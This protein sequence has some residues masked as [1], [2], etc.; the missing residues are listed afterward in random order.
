M[1]VIVAVYNVGPYIERCLHS[2]FGQTL[3]DMEYIFIDDGSTDGSDR[4]IGEVLEQ[5]PHRKAQTRIL[6]HG[7]NRGIAA[8]R[9]TGI[10]AATGEYVIHCDADDY[11]EPNMYR[12]LY[13][14]AAERDADI[15][16]CYYYKE[17]HGSSSVIHIDYRPTA[18]ESL[19]NLYCN[20]EVALWDKLV[21]RSLI[22]R[23]DIVPYEGVDYW[24]DL[25]CT[26]RML[27]YAETIYTVK[28]PLYHYCCRENSLSYAPG[29]SQAEACERCVELL[30]GF[31]EQADGRGYRI[32]TNRLRFHAKLLRRRLCGTDDRAW[33]DKYRESHRYI[34]KYKDIP[35][36]G[37]TALRITF[38]NYLTYKIFH[39]F[40]RFL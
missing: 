32:L 24:E 12:T 4:I 17:T 27:H 1:S 6:R 29:R 11:A 39:R 25:N 23:Y 7:T 3:D 13:S 28:E 18:R 19:K 37:R 34:L 30:C 10:R 33:F 16:T 31:L 5:Y 26:A 15:V 35:L 22:V 8:A 14:Y 20:F 40:F 38:L 21:R 36:R 9:T 2:L